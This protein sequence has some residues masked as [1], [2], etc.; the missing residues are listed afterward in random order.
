MNRAVKHLSIARYA[1][2]LVPWV[3]LGNPRL[4]PGATVLRPASPAMYERQYLWF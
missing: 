3:Y 4:K 2:S 1:G